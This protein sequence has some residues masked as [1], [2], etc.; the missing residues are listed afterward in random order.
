MRTASTPGQMTTL[1]DTSNTSELSPIRAILSSS[2][3]KLAVRR[4]SPVHHL[5]SAARS[6]CF[7]HPTV[8]PLPEGT[9]GVPA[10]S[11]SSVARLTAILD[12][13]AGGR[14]Q[15]AGYSPF[16]QRSF[17]PANTLPS[18]ISVSNALFGAGS[19]NIALQ[20]S[21]AECFYLRQRVASLEA[22]IVAC[23]NRRV[24]G[25]GRVL[26]VANG[27]VDALCRASRAAA[28]CCYFRRWISF[29]VHRHLGSSED[30]RR[31]FDEGPRRVRRPVRYHVDEASITSFRDTRSRRIVEKEDAD[32]RPQLYQR[33]HPSHLRWGSP[34]PEVLLSPAN[35]AD[36]FETDVFLNEDSRY[37]TERHQNFQTFERDPYRTTG[38]HSV[39]MQ[40]LTEREEPRSRKG[41][42]DTQ[43]DER[44]LI[45]ELTASSL[46]VV[47][48]ASVT[49]QMKVSSP[50]RISRDDAEPR[51]PTEIAGQALAANSIQSLQSA[52]AAAQHERSAARVAFIAVRTAVALGAESSKGLTQQETRGRKALI[53]SYREGLEGILDNM[54]ILFV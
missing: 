6:S 1:T 53:Q 17:I 19:S 54:S 14:Q 18:Q 40:V 25:A 31:C 45:L 12:G 52:S 21:A 50:E 13:A 3:R 22:Q 24:D 43:D 49:K 15:P 28:C 4:A 9:G 32:W 23:R 2:E 37:S 46:Q 20:T 41:I 26:V 7:E 44:R 33:D 48:L 11:S 42:A 47:H 36:C 39:L 38:S 35:G 8:R 30:G 29:V 10:P 16:Q 27:A 34:K 5:P 51:P